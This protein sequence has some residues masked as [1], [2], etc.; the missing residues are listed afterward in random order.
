MVL[1]R[2][3]EP[4]IQA[5]LAV[6]QGVSESTVS[7]TKTDKLEDAIA[8]IT[9]LGFKIVP[10]S[11]V[12]VDRAMYEAMATI[13]GRAMSDDSTARRLVWEED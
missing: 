7:R 11:K 6:A 12:C 1:Q 13:A 9:H 4:G 8:M 10:E 2:L 5:A 3:Q